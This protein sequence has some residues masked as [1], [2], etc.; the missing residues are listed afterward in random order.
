MRENSWIFFCRGEGWGLKIENSF[1]GKVKNKYLPNLKVL[2][3]KQAFCPCPVLLFS[4][5]LG[6]VGGGGW[7]F[8]PHYL[9][10]WQKAETKFPACCSR[11]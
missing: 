6:G 8:S 7:V 11:W 10:E 2:M 1:Q 5:S 3:S 4:L 9:E